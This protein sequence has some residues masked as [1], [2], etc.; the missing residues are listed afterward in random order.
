MHYRQA[1]L[2]LHDE[3]SSTASETIKEFGYIP[4]QAHMA[5]E[6]KPPVEW[7]KGEGSCFFPLSILMNQ[8]LFVL[9]FN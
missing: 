8:I 9:N 1:P 3:I 2:E 5:I 6:A 4:H 7:N